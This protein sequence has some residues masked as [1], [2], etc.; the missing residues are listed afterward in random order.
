VQRSL[1]ERPESHVNLGTLAGE[2][3]RW[4]E[5]ETHFADAI[6]IDPHWVPAY[7]NLADVQRQ[8]RGDGAAE[9]TLQEGLRR[10]PEA[11]A[12]AHALG[13]TLVREHRPA[14]AMPLLE[15][16][17]RLEPRNAPFGYGYGVALHAGG[18]RAGAVRELQRVVARDPASRDARLALAAYLSESGDMEAARRQLAELAAINPGDPALAGHP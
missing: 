3:G 1:A 6:R 15:R 16:A 17:A 8:S 7:V 12:I 4:A 5:A 2:R 11:A 9:A 13:L 14:E 18:R 10:N